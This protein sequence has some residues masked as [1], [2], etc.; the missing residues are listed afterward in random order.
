MLSVV[1]PGV[2]H[3]GTRCRVSIHRGN[4]LGSLRE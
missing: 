1:G 4:D 2:L 3:F